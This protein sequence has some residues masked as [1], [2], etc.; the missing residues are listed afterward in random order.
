MSLTQEYRA[1]VPCSLGVGWVTK[2][3]SKGWV[4]KDSSKGWVTKDSSKGQDA[5][6]SPHKSTHSKSN[7]FHKTMLRPTVWLHVFSCAMIATILQAPL[8]T[9]ECESGQSL[10]IHSAIRGYSKESIP[11]S[12]TICPYSSPECTM[13]AMESDVTKQCQHQQKC[14]MRAS[15]AIGAILWDSS[16]IGHAVATNFIQVNY[17]CRPVPV[18]ITSNGVTTEVNDKPMEQSA[19]N[20]LGKFN[21]AME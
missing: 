17:T 18:E 9:L 12:S 3:S 15:V 14:T 8:F 6:W 2:D 16:C 20:P 10:H 4:T 7:T 11:G 5:G 19:K 1:T 21:Q 13:S